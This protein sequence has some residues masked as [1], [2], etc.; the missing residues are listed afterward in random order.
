MSWRNTGGGFSRFEEV[1]RQ[2]IVRGFRVER[3]EDYDTRVQHK[4][5]LLMGLI[6]YC[7][8]SKDIFAIPCIHFTATYDLAL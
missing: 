8:H 5:A 1:K 3:E 4:C 6:Y 2:L 7:K